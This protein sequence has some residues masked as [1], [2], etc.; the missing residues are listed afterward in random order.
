MA[1]ASR[2]EFKQATEVDEFEQV[3]RLNY[4]TFVEEIPQHRPNP[5]S[6]LVDKFHAENTYFICKD[7]PDVVGM[8]AVR[9]QRPF[10][11][12]AKLEH[13]D[14]YLPPHQAVCEIRLLAVRKLYRH[15]RVFAG[16]LGQ[17]YLFSCRMGYDLAVISGTLRQ[18]RL[19]E[20]L[21]FVPFGPVVGSDDAPYQPMYLTRDAFLRQAGALIRETAAG[22]GGGDGREPVNLLPGP[23]AIAAPVREALQAA[24]VSHRSAAFSQLL[25]DTRE[26]LC[27]LV[28]SPHCD[29]ALGSGTLA[30]DLVAGQLS[31]IEGPGL[32]LSNGE[33]GERLIDHARRLG[34]SFRTHA[35]AWGQ[36]FAADAVERAAA[37]D[38]KVR[39]VWAVHLETSCGVLNDAAALAGVCRRHGT[40]LCLDCV[41]SI[42]N[43]AVDLSGV[44]L[45]SG[46]SGKGLG[47]YT[48]LA[49]VFRDHPLPPSAGRL[50]R[51]LDLSVYADH[52]GVPF[53][54]SSNLL[55][56]LHAAVCRLD[57][58]RRLRGIEE[59]SAWLRRELRSLGLPPLA[60][61]HCAAP[62]VL[63]IP[64]SAALDARE[65]GGRLAARGVLVSHESAYLLDRNWIQ[66]CLMRDVTL[67]DVRP[68]VD[69]LRNILSTSRAPQQ[70][71][72]AAARP[73]A[74][75]AV[76]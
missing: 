5:D 40:V 67:D 42:G 66:I 38:P 70:T 15:T 23:V 75:A 17:L 34:L 49:L 12:D 4:E 37:A 74:E 16:L 45:A 51:Y 2:L 59:V 20:H 14:R 9:A 8:I 58:D 28:R 26:R 24:P 60:D 69:A 56:A 13:L 72:P 44:H 76:P 22:E 25:G 39:W 11:L 35:V 36:P 55:S 32:I 41:S 63:T 33:F 50:P 53:S 27:A 1:D 46:V 71:A 57:L 7:G 3:C 62:A 54:T 18:I 21:G 65:L 61:E 31:L 73:P 19:Y 68:A 64:L 48:G 30:N 52:D 47:G 10:S 29:I 6:V 43:A